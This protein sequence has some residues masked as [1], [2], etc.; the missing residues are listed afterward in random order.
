MEILL[1]NKLTRFVVLHKPEFQHSD[2]HYQL[3]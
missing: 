3:N 1:L 2:L